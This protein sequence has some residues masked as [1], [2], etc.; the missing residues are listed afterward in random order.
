AALRA[1]ANIQPGRHLSVLRDVTA[2]K[3]AERALDESEKRYRALVE[4]STDVVFV[5]LP[6][7]FGYVSPSVKALF[8]YEPSELVGKATSDF[9]HPE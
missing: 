8:G 6:R 7:R 3:R 9:V 2:Q 5:T 4:S 1:T